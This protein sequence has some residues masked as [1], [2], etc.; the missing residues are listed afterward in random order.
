MVK[1]ICLFVLLIVFGNTVFSQTE[2][3]LIGKVSDGNTFLPG[4]NVIIVGRQIGATTSIDGDFQISNLPVE[5]I[6]LQFNYLGYESIEKT[7]NLKTGINNIGTITLKEGEGVLNEVLLKGFTAPSQI[8][9]L[10]LKSN[11]LAIM[12]VLSADAVG[13]LPDR[14]AAEAVQ[15]MPS[16]SVNRYHGEANQ[17]S[18][19]GTPY[20]W[21]STLYNGTRLPSASVFGGRNAILDAIPTEMIQ[22]IQLSKAITPD[23]EGDAIGGSVNFVS[24]MPPRKASL[25][26]TFG[27][28]YNEKANEPTYNGSIIYGDRFFKEKLGIVIAAS[29]WDRSFSTDEIVTEYNINS[30]EESQRYAINTVNA[31]RYNGRRA[32]KALS[33]TIDF[34]INDN[35]KVFGKFLIDRFRDLRP[36]YESF[37]DFARKRYVFS[38]R[39][40]D[41]KT[42]LNNFEIGGE[43][44]IGSKA[45]LDWSLANNDMSFLLDTPPNLGADSKGLPIA[46]FSQSLTG[47]FGNR[48]LDG[49]IY[50]HFDSPDENGIDLFNINPNLTNPDEDLLNPSK[51]LLSQLIIYQLDQRDKDKVGQVNL[52]VDFSEKFTFKTGAKLRFKEFSGEF[53]PAVFL[54]NAAVGIPD[55]APLATLSSLNTEPYPNSSSFFNEINNPF[56]NLIVNPI[57]K[58]QL[59]DIFSPQFFSQNDI[60][61]F[62]PGSNITTKYNGTENVYSAYIMGTYNVTKKLKLIGGVRNELTKV[63]TNSFQYDVS[64]DTATPINKNTNYNAF[65]PMVHLKYVLNDDI[66]LRLAFTRTFIRPNL[67]DLNP[68]ENIDITGGVPRITRGNTKLLPTFSNNFDVMGEYFLKDIGLITAGVFY[69]DLSDYIF[70]DISVENIENVSYIVTQ[71][72]NVKDASLLGFEAGITKRFLELDGFLSGFGVDFNGSIINSKLNVPRFDSDGALVTTDKTTLPNQSKLLFNSS[73]FYEKYGMM[74]RIAGNYRGK[75]LETINQNLGP[76]YYINVR[77]NFTVDFSA[78]YSIN[79]KIKIFMEVRNLTNE[80]FQQ[81]L[82]NN[83]NRYTSS[84]WSSINGQ[85]G[86]KYQIF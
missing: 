84:E 69:K 60:S 78:D 80:P 18:V 71:P 66:N 20:G 52:N 15:R 4:A 67:G 54:P 65:L 59:F 25:N 14:N 76:E 19:R 72:K 61:D 49:N 55:S 27:G 37:Y 74:F 41:Y 1:K 3:T 26:V 12:D 38:Y 32:T 22:Y 31:K 7:I 23:M 35:N 56:D 63:E 9:A 83:K 50:N 21:T 79:D 28:G 24:R 30:S 2:A 44:R 40:S 17:V 47:D 82:G 39:Y 73:I 43:H 85:L 86:L 10:N 48:A 77:S 45:K 34:E 70:R 6:K 62:S 5:D 53:T 81:Y 13:K 11:S 58:N 75:A 64:T 51:L 8:K 46:Q 57:T 29:I 16:V 68:S 33:G 42:S 36:V